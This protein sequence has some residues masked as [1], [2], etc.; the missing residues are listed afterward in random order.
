MITNIQAHQQNSDDQRIGWVL[1]AM[2]IIPALIIVFHMFIVTGIIPYSIVWGGQLTSTAEMLQFEAVSIGIN[3]LVIAVF[4]AEGGYIR[5]LLPYNMK[6]IVLWVLFGLFVANT[7]ANVFAV[8][9]IEKIVFTPLTLLF[10]VLT[11]RV[12]QYRKNNVGES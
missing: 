9:W 3:L 12:I 2:M 11:Y 4:A 6:T 1:K 5:K 7:V 10:A 8:S